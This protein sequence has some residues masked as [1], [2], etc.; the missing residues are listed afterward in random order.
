MR[1]GKLLSCAVFSAAALFGQGEAGRAWPFGGT[2]FS[3]LD[4]YNLGPLG[5][6]AADADAA[7]PAP[8]TSGVRQVARTNDG[9][10]ADKGP[11]RLRI[12]LLLHDGPAAKAGLKPGD[13]VVGVDGAAPFEKG[14]LKAIADALRKAAAQPKPSV[15]LLLAGADGKSKKLAVPL[16]GALK[17]DETD[18][19]KPAVR[20]AWARAGAKWLAERQQS[21]GGFPQ[22]L[23][24]ST[25]AVVQASV[26]GLA[27]IAVGGAERQS[28]HREAVDRAAKWVAK[29]VDAPDPFAG[30]RPQG[31][32]NW[33]QENWAWAHAALFLGELHQRAPSAQLKAD[34]QRCADALTK[35]QEGGGGWA[36]GPGGPNGLGYV[37]LNIMAG[38]AL[39]GL[40][41]A[42]QAGC[43]V[44]A[45]ALGRAMDYVERS[46][47]GGGVGY[48][49]NDGQKGIGNIGRTAGCWLGY[50]A[51]GFESKKFCDEM[52]GYVARSVS[53][54]L[55]GHAS[56]MQQTLLAGVAAA[57]LGGEPHRRFW[58]DLADDALLARAPDGS[59]QPR[60]WHESISMGTNSDVSCGDVWTT[61]CWT[62]VLAADGADKGL[63][64]LAGWAGLKRKT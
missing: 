33:N 35:N 11:E 59:F 51:L 49:T 60:P 57:A 27:W 8:R 44:D 47:S 42:K 10:K 64:G 56:L 53:D 48:S 19:Q 17:K 50:R 15:V 12:E 36:H 13:V 41:L 62:I 6:K 52:K 16:A 29:T 40:G 30:R 61:A 9:G 58:A 39:G 22:T 54:V 46:S 14:S 55:G 43:K 23:G 26:A 7:P 2:R 45:G 34:L 20:G 32:A 5:A 3:E 38:L 31:G 4:L 24:G 1:S 25:G 37:E 21:D 63:A 18:P 28:P